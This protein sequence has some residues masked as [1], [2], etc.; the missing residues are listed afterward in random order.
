MITDGG[1]QSAF[2]TTGQGV[3]LFDASRCA[4]SPPDWSMSAPRLA[5]T[6]RG[7]LFHGPA[8]EPG[9]SP[10]VAQ[11]TTDELVHRFCGA[12]HLRSD[13]SAAH[14]KCSVEQA[15]LNK[16]R[17]LVPVDVLVRD[18]VALELVLVMMIRCS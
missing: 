18:L 14:R 3:I 4:S 15:N 12:Q 9:E 8:A 7:G 6:A 2:V 17:S 11:R 5:T 10:I 16:Q 13:L 1:Y